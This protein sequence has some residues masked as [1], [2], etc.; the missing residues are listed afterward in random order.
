MNLDD[1][2]DQSVL[3]PT[4]FRNRML[5]GTGGEN[6]LNSLNTACC[7]HRSSQGCYNVLI[8]K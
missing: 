1:W 7:K 3:L 6:F 5:P 4:T 2:V 8:C